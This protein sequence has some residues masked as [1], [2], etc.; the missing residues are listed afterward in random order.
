MGKAQ[1]VMKLLEDRNISVTVPQSVYTIAKLYEHAGVT[2]G[3]YKLFEGVDVKDSVLI[4]PWSMRR[5]GLLDGIRNKRTA[6]LTGWALNEG[7]RSRFGTDTAFPLSDHADFNGLLEYVRRAQPKNVYTVHGSRRSC[8]YLR[9][10]G[11]NAQS[12]PLKS[13]PQLSLW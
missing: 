9:E 8:K 7:T 5:Q 10:A 2:F 4:G 13:S 12:L 3:P 11:F 1:E 6:A